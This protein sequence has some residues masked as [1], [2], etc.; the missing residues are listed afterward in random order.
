MMNWL[1]FIGLVI[2]VGIIMLVMGYWHDK[3]G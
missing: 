1:E 2:T 3:I